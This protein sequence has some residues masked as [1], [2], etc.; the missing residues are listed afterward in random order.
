[1][2]R[3]AAQQ[4]LLGSGCPH[5]GVRMEDQP[6][7]GPQRSICTTPVSRLLA[8]LLPSLRLCSACRAGGC[9]H[10]HTP[11]FQKPQTPTRRHFFPSWVWVQE[12]P[13]A[14]GVS[15]MGGSPRLTQHCHHSSLNAPAPASNLY[16]CPGHPP[17]PPSTTW[18]RQQPGPPLRKNNVTS[19]MPTMPGGLQ[20]EW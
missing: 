11:C 15:K 1:M 2:Q 8:L 17:P 16:H 19:T 20:L 3:S 13:Q 7:T 12:A 14:K 4:V 10:V 18:C 5:A 6:G 9:T